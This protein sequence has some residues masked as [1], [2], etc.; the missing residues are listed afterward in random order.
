MIPWIHSSIW[1]LVISYFGHVRILQ[2]SDSIYFGTRF[3]NSSTSSG[4][5]DMKIY[6]YVALDLL[7][8]AIQLSIFSVK[9]PLFYDDLKIKNFEIQNSLL[10]PTTKHFNLA[11]VYIKT[12][13]LPSRAP[14]LPQAATESICD[15]ISIRTNSN[16]A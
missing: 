4:L 5:I 10:N 3:A 7:F 1:M 13:S 8:P 14:E 15:K 2:S 16:L 12:S 9:I 11:I 6:H